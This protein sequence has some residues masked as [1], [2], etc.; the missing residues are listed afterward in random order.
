MRFLLALIATSFLLFLKIKGM[1][2]WAFWIIFSPLWILFILYY[3][4]EGFLDASE[5]HQL[6]ANA[7]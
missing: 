6:N 5:L 7:F 2:D 3:V 4:I 1:I